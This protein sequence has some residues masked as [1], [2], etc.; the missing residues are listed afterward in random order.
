MACPSYQLSKRCCT[1]FT[2]AVGF[3]AQKWAGTRLSAPH[4]ISRPGGEASRSIPPNALTVNVADMPGDLLQSSQLAITV[5]AFRVIPEGTEAGVEIN[6]ASLGPHNMSFLQI[7]APYTHV[8]RT[9]PE[10][11]YASVDEYATFHC[12]HTIALQREC[13]PTTAFN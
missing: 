7:T 5:T 8:Q 11:V 9:P 12:G 6:S 3:Q 2:E 13:V 10:V 1:V 4:D